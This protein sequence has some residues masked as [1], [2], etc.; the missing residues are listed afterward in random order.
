MSVSLY[1]YASTSRNAGVG[2][3]DIVEADEHSVL[4]VAI[5]PENDNIV[6]TCGQ[7]GNI[8]LWDFRC[9]TN[10]C[11]QGT[12]VGVTSVNCVAFNPVMPNL[13]LSCD[14]FGNIM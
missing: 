12:I 5:Q 4:K 11:A 10:Q 8:S 7:G 6:L 9:R 13:F 14:D 2:P 1:N 3:V